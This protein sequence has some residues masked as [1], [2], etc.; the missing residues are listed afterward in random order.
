MD[1]HRYPT[2]AYMMLKQHDD[3]GRTNWASHVRMLLYIFGFG[4][5]WV[6]H[7][8]GNTSALISE[9]QQRLSDSLAQDWSSDIANSSRCDQYQYFKTL[10]NVE[11][12]LTCH[13]PFYLRKA[14]SKFRCSN[15]C[16]MIEVGRHLGLERNLRFCQF[17]IMHEGLEV[18]ENEMHA[19]FECKLLYRCT[20]CIPGS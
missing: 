1:S 3:I 5:A 20:H 19:F 7:D 11:R 4:Y 9:F 15:H 8:V 12:Y 6:A 17:C 10:L 18:L 13:L 2:N 14:I 16:L